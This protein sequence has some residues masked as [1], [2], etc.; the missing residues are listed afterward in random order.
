MGQ[1]FIIDDVVSTRWNCQ[2]RCNGSAAI[3]YV[4]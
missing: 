4:N 1:W 2:R 3:G